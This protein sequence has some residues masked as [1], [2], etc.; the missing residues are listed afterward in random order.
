MARLRMAGFDGTCGYHVLDA[1]IFF[2]LYMVIILVFT[3]IRYY[4]VHDVV[5]GHY[6][7]VD[8]ACI[9]N[10]DAFFWI[11]ESLPIFDVRTFWMS[12]TILW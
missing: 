6:R 4:D 12:V 1:M 10:K 2:M 7:S 3:C 5:H 8:Q 11:V 9:R